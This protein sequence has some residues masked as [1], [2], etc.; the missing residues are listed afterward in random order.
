VRFVDSDNTVVILGSW[1]VS[2]FTPDWV[3]KYIFNDNIVKAE[4]LLDNIFSIHLTA[5]D[6]Q[7][8]VSPNRLAITNKIKEDVTFEQ[9]QEIV[10]KLSEYLPHTPVSA[11][12]INFKVQVDEKTKILEKAN[13]P[14][15]KELEKKGTVDYEIKYTVNR[16]KSGQMTLSVSEKESICEFDVNFHFNIKKLA[17]L[18]QTLSNDSES[19]LDYKTKTQ[20]VISSLISSCEE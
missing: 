3:K 17:D 11:F 12:G 15:F 9:I 2:I 1:N 14:F 10:I 16:G 20:S 8:F 19:I 4:I 7:I 18:K 6:F 5:D 13:L